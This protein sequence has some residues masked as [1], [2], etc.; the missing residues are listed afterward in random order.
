MVYDV[1]LNFNG[2]ILMSVVENDFVGYLLFE[3]MV[4][5]D[6]LKDVFGYGLMIG[7]FDFW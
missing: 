6:V 3:C 5:V 4:S 1:D 2:Y 7:L